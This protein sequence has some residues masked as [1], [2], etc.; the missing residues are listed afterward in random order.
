MSMEYLY[1]R[2]WFDFEYIIFYH[3]A[4]LTDLVEKQIF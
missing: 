1:T 3:Y 2:P 4:I